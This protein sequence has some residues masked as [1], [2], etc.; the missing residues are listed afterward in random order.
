MA[1]NAGPWVSNKLVLFGLKFIPQMALVEDE[2]ACQKT[3]LRDILQP[4]SAFS[5]GTI[6]HIPNP[7]WMIPKAT[8]EFALTRII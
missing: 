5:N 3:L 2:D 6:A 7:T 8:S 1:P 4:I